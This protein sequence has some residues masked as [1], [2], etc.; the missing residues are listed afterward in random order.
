MTVSDTRPI[1]KTQAAVPHTA[2]RGLGSPLAW[3][4]VSRLGIA[5]GLILLLWSGVFWALI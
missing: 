4:V 3:G 5:I 1:G 2:K